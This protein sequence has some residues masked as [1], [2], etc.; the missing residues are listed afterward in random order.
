MS[1]NIELIKNALIKVIAKQNIN[2]INVI[3]EKSKNSLFGDYA[4]NVA[5]LIAKKTNKNCLII[6]NEIV[7]ELENNKLFS[8]I[9][10]KNPGFI[11]FF[12]NNEYLYKTINQINLL[13]DRYGA[14]LKKSIYYNLEM[15]SANPTGPLHIGHGRN[16]AVGDSVARILAFSGYRVSTE[17]YIN[18]AGNQVNILAITLFSYYLQILGVNVEIPEDAYKGEYQKDTAQIFVNKYDKKY[19]NL[20]VENGL[21]N[22]E[23]V[24]QLFKTEGVAIYLAIIKNQLKLFGVHIDHWSSELENY[25]NQGIEKLISLYKSLDKTYEKDGA[26]FLKTTDYGDDK[27]RVLIKKDK[28]YTYILPDLVCHNLRIQRTGCDFLVNFWGA[29]HH[30]YIARLSAGLQMLNYKADILKID[31][32]QMVRLIKDGAEYKMSKRKGTAVWLNDLITDFGVDGIRYMLLSKTPSSH[33][34]FDLNLLEEKSSKNPVYYLQYATARCVS[35]LNKVDNQ[36]HFVEKFNLLVSS[37]EREILKELDYFYQIINVAA[38]NRQP[39]IICDYLQGLVKLFHSYYTEY[40]IL[41]ENNIDLSN[42]RITLIKAIYQ[43]I[44]NGLNLIGV[45]SK[46]KM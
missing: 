32:T 31:I 7:K 19:I 3:I 26:L 41:D 18:D 27:D 29:D 38:N 6:A 21:I 46:Q 17:Y 24:H 25:K 2:D 44:N 34:D 23:I 22:D 12:I 42:E 36:F 11:N 43:V 40:Q 30:G 28:S 1:P 10:V 45:N 14:G 9:E 8:K 33:M 39:N 13:K 4:S 20:R 15:V 16:G 5:L 35:L 37:K